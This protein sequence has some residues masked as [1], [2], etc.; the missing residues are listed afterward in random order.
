VL[1]N[2]TN[3]FDLLEDLNGFELCE[4]FEWFWEK[5]VKIN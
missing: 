5:I 2:P 1:E 3:Y 4:T